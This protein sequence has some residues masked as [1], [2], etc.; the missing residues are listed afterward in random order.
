MPASSEKAPPLALGDRVRYSQGYLERNRGVWGKH[1]RRV[2]TVVR[3]EPIRLCDTVLW[4][5]G[6]H[7]D[8]N[9][10]PVELLD[11]FLEKAPGQ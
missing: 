10:H 3:T 1:R 9:K 2:G 8:G 6:V 7:W 5:V 11:T 4:R